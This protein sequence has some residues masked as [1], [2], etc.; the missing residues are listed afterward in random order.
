[1]KGDNLD[2]TK[3][4]VYFLESHLEVLNKDITIV[5]ESSSKYF[6]SLRKLEE[7]VFLD[8]D[9]QPF[10]V[11]AYAVD[12]NSKDLKKKESKDGKTCILKLSQKDKNGDKFE[13]E[14]LILLNKDTLLPSIKFYPMKK[15]FGKTVSA[16]M[17]LNLSTLQQIQMLSDALAKDGKKENEQTFLELQ[18]FGLNSLNKMNNYEMILFYI[19]YIDILNG[20]DK[21]LIKDIFAIFDLKKMIKPVNQQSLYIY[22]EKMEAIYKNQIQIFDIIKTIPNCEFN[23]YLIKFYTIYINLYSSTESYENC[24]RI[25]ND[26]KDNNPFDNLILSKLY[27]SEYSSF[28]RNI[29]ISNNIKNSLIVKYINSSENYDNLQ[30][31]FSIIK[32]YINSDFA[33]IL[34]IIIDNYEKINDICLRR[35]LPLKLNDYIITKE[36]DDLSKIQ[37]YL[38]ILTQ[39]KLN[40]KYKCIDIELRTYDLY[41]SNLEKN[42][43]FWEFFKSNIIF[44]SLSYEEITE[45]LTYIS[46]YFGRDFIKMLELIVTNYDKLREICMNEKKHIIISNYIEQNKNNDIEKIK[47]YLNFI[48]TQKLKDQYE[49]ILFDVNI[50]NYYVFNQF[51]MDFLTYLEKKL[52]E[53]SINSKDIDDCL[54]Y[55]SNFRSKNFLSM[56]QII[57]FNFNIIQDIS[58]REKVKFSIAK[59][60]HQQPNNDDLFKIYDQIKIIIEKEQPNSYPSINFDVKIWMPYTQSLVL[61]T[62][63]FIRKIISECKKMEPDLNEDTI[64]LTR[65]IHDIG[66]VEIK[67]GTL[68]GEKLLEFLGDEEIYYRDK[69]TYDLYQK[70]VDFQ[71]Q[72]NNHANVI[73]ELNKQHANLVKVVN[74]LQKKVVDLTTQNAAAHNRIRQLESEN[75]KINGELS[76]IYS[77]IRSLKTRIN[78]GQHLP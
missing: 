4:T 66:Y 68:T 67:K 12:Y 61:A 53:G 28:Y 57:N 34:S 32:D 17:N 46:R 14:I 6:K 25:I 74:D 73:N 7:K 64:L 48:I 38:D 37:Y 60:I 2:N 21:N 33:I 30:I 77:D 78:F 45:D 18:R 10:I 51:N 5:L 15:L 69:T 47:E 70:N 62:L 39:K 56:L 27:L 8:K 54:Q 19:L 24:D 22:F 1:M 71:N 43:K 65:K 20:G 63:R 11:S 16:P 72:L 42:Q 40:Y 44:G 55:S 49:T 31:A 3:N 58:R 50:W 29:P 41:L 52:Y 35:K 23:S 9:K 13:S 26:L 76:R 36:N 59:F 75:S